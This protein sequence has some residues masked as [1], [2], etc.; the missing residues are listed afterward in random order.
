MK[1]A[2]HKIHI[3][4]LTILISPGLGQTQTQDKL[5]FHCPPLPQSTTPPTPHA[6]AMADS[7]AKEALIPLDMETEARIAKVNSRSRQST[8][9]DSARVRA[10]FDLLG[11]VHGSLHRYAGIPSQD[12]LE[13]ALTDLRQALLLNPD[14]VAALHSIALIAA[15]GGHDYACAEALYLRALKIEPANAIIHF[16]YAELLAYQGK[17]EAAFR[18][19]ETAMALADQPSKDL[20]QWR[21]MRMHYM[22]KNYDWVINQCDQHIEKTDQEDFW[23]NGWPAYYYKGLALAEQEKYD[24]AL[25]AELLTYAFLS[26]D[27][28]NLA[29]SARAYAMAGDTAVAKRVLAAVLEPDFEWMPY[30]IAT[31]YEAL[32]DFDNTFLWLNIAADEGDEWLRWL[33][34]DPRWK[35]IRSDPRFKKVQERAGG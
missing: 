3:I 22:A 25:E 24:Q 26:T 17:F 30:E 21:V 10:F 33:K 11:S 31:A 28:F 19:A 20:Y 5:S 12:K 9:S 34:L 18:Y 14:L 2:I 7:L 27:G 23:N 16:D 8:K 1:K 15:R 4:C 13:K 6:L 29:S 32:G 35:R